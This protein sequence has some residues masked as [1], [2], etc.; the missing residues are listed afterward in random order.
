MQL[1]TYKTDDRSIQEI[2]LPKIWKHAI[3]DNSKAV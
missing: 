1:P 2:K 3:D